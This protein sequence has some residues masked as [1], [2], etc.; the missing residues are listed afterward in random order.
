M[1]SKYGIRLTSAALRAGFALVSKPLLLR[2]LPLGVIT[3]ELFAGSIAATTVY[4]IL[5]S[6]VRAAFY[7][8]VADSDTLRTMRQ[9]TAQ[10]IGFVLMLGLSSVLVALPFAYFYAG[11]I[12]IKSTTLFLLTFF[13]YYVSAVVSDTIFLSCNL[14]RLEDKNNLADLLATGVPLFTSIFPLLALRLAGLTG[15]LFA[16]L[17]LST[18]YACL[19]LWKCN[20]W[21]CIPTKDY[22]FEV[23]NVF[24]AMA[25]V[26]LVAKLFPFVE[27]AALSRLGTGSITIYS[28]AKGI[29]SSFL[30]IAELGFLQ[31]LVASFQLL[32]SESNG[33]LL[34]KKLKASNRIT[35]LCCAVGPLALLMPSEIWIRTSS[36]LGIR[37]AEDASTLLQCIV[38][39]SPFFGASICAAYTMPILYSLGEFEFVSGIA[40]PSA[41]IN[42]V[43]I[44]ISSHYFGIAGAC[45]SLG[46]YFC[47]NVFFF[48]RRALWNCSSLHSVAG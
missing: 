7:K 19:V 3:D 32:I 41:L 13:C 33:H 17:A 12:N 25:G 30:N 42:S 18:I 39:L 40:M 48:Y 16:I 5:T 45:L 26:S 47:M 6:Q 23:L 15:Y 24:N 34:K 21:P 38:T 35:L 9:T 36:I 44:L 20:S 1:H 29:Y 22:I 10:H 46:A 11:L 27:T 43:A 8:T 31:R 2:L 4:A 14:S 28:L 37:T